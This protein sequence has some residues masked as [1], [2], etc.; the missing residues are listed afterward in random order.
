MVVSRVEGLYVK[1]GNLVHVTGTFQVS[2]KGSS[3]GIARLTGLPY[4]IASN[5][6]AFAPIPDRG[7]INLGSNGQGAAVFM[8]NTST[9]KLYGYDFDGTGNFP[10]QHS[11]F[12]FNSELDV[13]FSYRT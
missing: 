5:G 10:L 13:N 7:G 6:A 8:Q 12:H 2:N 11:H 1:I 3:T 9:P 4:P